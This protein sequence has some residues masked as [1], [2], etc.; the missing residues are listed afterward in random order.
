VGA[1]DGVGE[2]VGDGELDTDDGLGVTEASELARAPTRPQAVDAV[3]SSAQIVMTAT[4][5]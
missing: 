5:L 1:G 3:V 4:V 2:A